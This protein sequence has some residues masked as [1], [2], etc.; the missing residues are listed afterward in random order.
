[1]RRV[2]LNRRRLA[3]GAAILTAVFAA[4]AAFRQWVLPYCVPL[5]EEEL[6]R[7][8]PARRFFDRAGR[9]LHSRPGFDYEWRFP[10]RLDALP[11]HLVEIT[12]AVEDRNF[13]RHD[14]VDLAASARAFWQLLK[15]GRIVSGSSTVTMQLMN[16][17]DR[18]PR[19]RLTTP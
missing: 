4:A 9:L 10:V 19:H 16:L 5:P 11:A 1:M 2:I 15:Y 12:L 7:R 3:A 6:A 14:G 17:A 13:Y 18:R 8:I